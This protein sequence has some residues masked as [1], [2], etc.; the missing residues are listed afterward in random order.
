MMSDLRG[1]TAMSERMEAGDLLT[2]L[3][4][5]LGE[6]TEEIQK[7]NGTIIKFNGDGIM[8]IFGAPAPS[9]NHAADAIAAAV[10]MQNRMKEINR[11]NAEQGYPVLEMGIGLNT[12]E[13]IVGNIGSEK[14]TK[15]GVVGSHVN[16]C[17]R[18]ESYTVGGQILVSPLT[19]EMAGTDLE[20]A[21]EM[22]VFPKGVKGVLVLSHVTGIGEPFNFSCAAEEDV[23]QPLD[24]PKDVEFVLIQGKH[25]DQQMAV[26]RFVAVSENGAM[27]QTDHPLKAHDNIRLEAGG[28]LFAKVM[29]AVPQGWVLRFTALPPDYKRWLEQKI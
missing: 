5:Y 28:D 8:A 11:W 16:L 25:V 22:E 13:V 12:G 2:M 26:G 15:Y 10:Q 19:G 4:H 23:F 9:E 3:N 17:D 24:T 21:Q 20:I 14:R 27:M 18:I 1:F 7:Y 6:M 29:K